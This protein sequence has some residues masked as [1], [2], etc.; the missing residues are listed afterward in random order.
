MRGEW[1][2]GGGGGVLHGILTPCPSTDRAVGGPAA[3]CLGDRPQLY[4]CPAYSS[5]PSSHTSPS[6]PLAVY[7]GLRR[8]RDEV[9][10]ALVRLESAAL[11]EGE[12]LDVRLAAIKVTIEPHSCH[13]YCHFNLVA[14]LMTFRSERI[15]NFST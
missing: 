5:S 7:H 12:E 15:S 14:S 13:Q 8:Q 11:G 4:R 6:H 3:D 9:R 2:K 1:C 10:E